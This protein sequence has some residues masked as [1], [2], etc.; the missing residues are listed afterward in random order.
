[1]KKR[2]ESQEMHLFLEC[3]NDKIPAMTNVELHVVSKNV[4]LVNIFHPHNDDA[5]APHALIS[6]Q[7]LVISENLVHKSTP[8][9]QFNS[10]IHIFA[11]S[12]KSF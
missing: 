11:L 4:I 5:Q 3:Q 10:E 6:L 12:R 8:A 1:M 7:G 2:V 9:F